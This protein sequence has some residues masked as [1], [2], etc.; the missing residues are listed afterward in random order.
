MF[1][2]CIGRVFARIALIHIGDLDRFAGLGLDPL[3]KF[4]D[5]STILLVGSCHTQGEQV[6]QGVDREMDFITFAAFRT[7]IAGMSA[8]QYARQ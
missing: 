7:V 5:L 6:S 4:G 1:C 3:G 8:A 2:G